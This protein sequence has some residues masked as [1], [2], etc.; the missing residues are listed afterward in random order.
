LDTLPSNHVHTIVT[1]PPYW[2]LR[3]YGVV[4]QIGMEPTPQEHVETMVRLCRELRRVLRPDGLL[5]MNYGDMWASSVNGRSASDTK[6]AGN[7]DRTFR[8]KPFSTV[9]GGL[10]AKDLVGMPWRIALALQ[11]DGWWLRDCVIWHKPNPMPSSVKSRCTPAYEYVF[12]LAK[13]EKYYF[14]HAAIKEPIAESSK[15]RYAQ[16]TIDTQQGGFKQ[17]QYESGIAGA[18]VRSRRPN[19]IIKSLAADGQEMRAKRNVWTIPTQPVKEAH[20]ATF[21]ERLVEPC[22]LAGAPSGGT[23]LD[24]FFGSGTTG[25]VAQRLGRNCIGIELNPAY[26]EIARARL[27]AL[28]AD[29]TNSKGGDRYGEEGKRRSQVLAHESDESGGVFG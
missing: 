5:W 16:A 10:K 24:P 13:S 4:G 1:S 6:A 27:A 12:M 25:V 20:F 26:I 29:T 14:D 28:A 17:D 22:I 11:A 15:K 18:R 3:D 21:P 7:D 9:V 23:V 2:G 8:D 19:E